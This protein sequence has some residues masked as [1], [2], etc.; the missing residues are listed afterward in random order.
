MDRAFFSLEEKLT[1]SF[2]LGVPNFDLPFNVET[3]VSSIS[4]DA[5]LAQNTANGKLHPS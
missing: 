4:L 3:D 5:F 1:T 2:V